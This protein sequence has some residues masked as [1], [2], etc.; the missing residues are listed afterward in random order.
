M[1]A[2]RNRVGMAIDALIRGTLSQALVVSVASAS[3]AR[4]A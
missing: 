2:G 3:I 1:T 4:T